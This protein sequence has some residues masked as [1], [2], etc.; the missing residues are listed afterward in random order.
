MIISFASQKGGSGKTSG[1]VNIGAALHREGLKV[2]YVDLD[3]QACLTQQLAG[4][5]T[6]KTTS[7][8]LQLRATIDQ[9]TT[10][11][12]QGTLVPADGRLAG[13]TSKGTVNALQSALK[14]VK[15]RYDAILLDCPPQ[16]GAVTVAALAA[17]DGVII[18]L[19]PDLFG[20]AALQQ[21]SSIIE[22][23]QEINTGLKVLGVLVTRYNA[24]SNSNKFALQAITEQ[25]AAL[26]IS[27]YKTTI[28]NS[29]AVQDAMWKPGAI[30]DPHSGAAKDYEAI[31][32]QVIKQI[33]KGV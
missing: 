13:I 31:A 16:L 11:T 15:T 28:R 18:P 9:A 8:V 21:I 5:V 14:A 19:P 20:I 33:R 10:Q 26:N 24:R 2:L 1:V 30:L 23:V 17:S 32:E 27:V 29:V 12:A 3:Q 4:R 25:A 22:Q 6:G 7:D